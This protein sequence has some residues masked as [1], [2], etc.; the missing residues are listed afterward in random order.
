MYLCVIALALFFGLGNRF[1]HKSDA[2]NISQSTPQ[3][4][5]II[6]V[7]TLTN[8]V[9]AATASVL[10]ICAYILF[11]SALIG[12]LSPLLALFSVPLSARAFL[13]CLFEISSGAK[14]A[15]LLESPMLAATLCGFAVGWSGLSVHF[16]IM[17]LAANR[18][19]DFRPYWLSKFL[20]G[21]FCA[22]VS[23]LYANI[24]PLTPTRS[25]QAGI[26]WLHTPH[27]PYVIAV[28][29]LFSAGVLLVLLSH[30]GGFRNCRP[31]FLR[32]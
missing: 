17:S 18:D 7:N 32:R 5:I 19:I 28:L 15:S 31:R 30:F 24:Y 6:N 4:H 16:Q 29:V 13:F 12:C 20:Q 2:T 23:F 14:A 3:T 27:S 9:S 8:A 10:S 21:L 1:F 22:L 26:L 11:F 25:Q